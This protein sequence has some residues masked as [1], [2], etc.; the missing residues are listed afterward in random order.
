MF[1]PSLLQDWINPTG[2]RKVHSLI[3][4]V[5]KPTAATR[6]YS[7]ED[8]HGGWEVLARA[9]S[10]KVGVPKRFLPTTKTFAGGFIATVRA[11]T[12]ARSQRNGRPRRHCRVVEPSLPGRGQ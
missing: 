4:K 1:T 3:D 6:R 12:G 9:G 5:Y 2:A 8:S 10:Q 11:D 7:A